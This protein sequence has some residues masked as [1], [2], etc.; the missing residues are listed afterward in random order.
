MIIELPKGGY[1]PAFRLSGAIKR[2][3]RRSRW[4]SLGVA[5]AAFAVAVAAVAWWWVQHKSAPVSIAVLPLT[6]LSQEPANEYFTDGLTDEII[7]NLSIID[8]LAV[9]S[10]T[11]SFVF[12]GKA[13]NTGGRKT[14]AGRL[15]FGGFRIAQRAAVADQCPV[16]SR[17]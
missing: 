12:K 17:A 15:H 2:G 14:T 7:R 16:S 13:R 9:R 1:I 3:E 6:N 4:L 11:S 10:Q 5:M 8:G